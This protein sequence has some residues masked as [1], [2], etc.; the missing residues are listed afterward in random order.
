MMNE[1]NLSSLDIRASSFRMTNAFAMEAN[2]VPVG[3]AGASPCHKA[4]PIVFAK[5]LLSS[6]PQRW[7]ATQLP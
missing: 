3:V 2:P 6:R 1:G 4:D 5:G 7:G